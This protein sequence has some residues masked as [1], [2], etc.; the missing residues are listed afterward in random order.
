MATQ[1]IGNLDC[2][3]IHILPESLDFPFQYILIYIVCCCVPLPAP[4]TYHS[5]LTMANLLLQLF[6]MLLIRCPIDQ[7]RTSPAQLSG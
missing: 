4:S 7:H 2:P 5:S 1:D 3:L 6:C